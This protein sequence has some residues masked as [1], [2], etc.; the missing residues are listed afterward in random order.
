[1]VIKIMLIL[2]IMTI[3]STVLAK[4]KSV[5]VC[6]DYVFSSTAEIE[7]LRNLA[8]EQARFLASEELG[9]YIKSDTEI[10]LNTVSK[11][12]VTVLVRSVLKEK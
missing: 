9:T 6:I 8:R 11:D 12:N 3:N 2:I 4:E 10:N 1:M 5:E 7:E